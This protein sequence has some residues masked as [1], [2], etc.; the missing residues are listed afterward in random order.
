MVRKG[1]FFVKNR[2]SELRYEKVYGGQSRFKALSGQ[3]S[4]SEPP[5]DSP[6][7]AFRDLLRL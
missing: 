1:I 7:G 4:A 3:K 2:G 5:D 6:A